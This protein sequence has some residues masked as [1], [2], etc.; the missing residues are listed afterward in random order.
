MKLKNGKNQKTTTKQVKIGLLFENKPNMVQNEE[1]MEEEINNE[2]EQDDSINEAFENIIGDRA[3]D[4]ESLSVPIQEMHEGDQSEE[5][6][7]IEAN[8][9]AEADIEESADENKEI[10]IKGLRPRT[11][12]ISYNDKRKYNKK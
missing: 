11:K 3:C 10:N 9:V 8:Q 12:P 1:V 4:L 5:D 7:E 2:Q 6:T